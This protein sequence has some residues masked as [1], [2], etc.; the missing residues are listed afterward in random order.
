[1]CTVA[2]DGNPSKLDESKASEY[3]LH[4]TT[5]DLVDYYIINSE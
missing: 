4:K 3:I 5:G 1:M 2:A